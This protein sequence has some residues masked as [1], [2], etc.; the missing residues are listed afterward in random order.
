MPENG[1]FTLS[2]GG[3]KATTCAVNYTLGNKPENAELVQQ[4]VTCQ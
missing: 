4:A 2:W 1:R 3:D